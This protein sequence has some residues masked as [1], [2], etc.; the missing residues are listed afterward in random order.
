MEKDSK[1]DKLSPETIELKEWFSTANNAD[2]EYLMR[3]IKKHNIC[4]SREK[5]LHLEMDWKTKLSENPRTLKYREPETGMFYETIDIQAYI[6][7]CKFRKQTLSS[8]DILDYELI[9]KDRPQKL[10]FWVLK[11]FED[12]MST[13]SDTLKEFLATEFK[14]DTKISIDEF[15]DRLIIVCTDILVE[16]YAHKKRLLER[17]SSIYKRYEMDQYLRQHV[18][19]YEEI[20]SITNAAYK[21]AG[22]TALI[23]N[24]YQLTSAIKDRLS[25]ILIMGFSG[26]ITVNIDTVNINYTTNNYQSESPYRKF[27]DHVTTDLPKWYNPGEWIPKQT[28]TDEFNSFNKTSINTQE[29]IRNLKSE[30]LYENICDGEKRSRYK[31]SKGSIRLFKAK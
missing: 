4:M 13:F 22:T 25:P 23:E 10:F 3:Q 21:N 14:K 19:T 6:Q 20:P 18:D 28:L 8:Q 2:L 15:G 11:H 5:M 16:N 24:N 27:V 1:Q 7:D 30:G 31:G 9:H 29:L 17:F 26:P 12:H